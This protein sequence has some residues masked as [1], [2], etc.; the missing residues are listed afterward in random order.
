MNETSIPF[1]SNISSFVNSDTY[2]KAIAHDL[3]VLVP[4]IED[5]IQVKLSSKEKWDHI[6]YRRSSYM[7]F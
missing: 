4:P 5:Y 1:L 7:V 2:T 6:L 3:V